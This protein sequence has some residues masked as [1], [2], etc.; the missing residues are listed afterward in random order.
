M[1][2]PQYINSSRLLRSLLQARECLKRTRGRLSGYFSVFILIFIYNAFFN[3][4]RKGKLATVG[5]LISG[6]MRPGLF[7]RHAIC[8]MREDEGDMYPLRTLFV[9]PAHQHMALHSNPSLQ[10]LSV[11]PRPHPPHLCIASSL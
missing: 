8:D 1:N 6:R 11:L 7:H 3:L 5:L 2:V 4:Y 9:W 10:S